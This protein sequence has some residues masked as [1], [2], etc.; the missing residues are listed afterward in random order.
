M[1]TTASGIFRRVAV[2]L[3]STAFTLDDPSASEFFH[4]AEGLALDFSQENNPIP[5]MTGTTR[6]RQGEIPGFPSVSV[7]LPLVVRVSGTAGTVPSVDPLLEG[8]FWTADTANT[9]DAVAA[10]PSP[11]TTTYTIGTASNVTA[12]TFVVVKSSNFSPA[13]KPEGR[14]CTTNSSGAL[15]VTPPHSAAPVASSVISATN[16]Y[17]LR[18][19]RSDALSVWRYIHDTANTA[20]IS[21]AVPG[22]V[23]SNMVIEWANEGDGYL[24]FNFS[25][26][27]AGSYIYTSKTTL[28]AGIGNTTDTTITIS[29]LGAISVG[30]RIVVDSECMIVT[31]KSALSGSGTVTVT[32]GANSTT[33]ATHSNGAT[34]SPYEPTPSRTSQTPIPA[35]YC[36]VFIGPFATKIPATRITCTIEDNITLIR[37]AAGQEGEATDYAPGMRDITLEIEVWL[38]SETVNTL[39]KAKEGDGVQVFVQWGDTV[40]KLVMLYAPNWVLQGTPIETSGDAPIAVTLRGSCRRNSADEDELVLGFG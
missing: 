7:E 39:W 6:S 24:N 5:D 3:E 15:T 1:A 19:G 36:D 9:A 18:A 2:A 28:G 30:S 34:V 16:T 29:D 23:P 8:S 21:E 11:S 10:S 14:F 13:N 31:S 37:S 26:E 33:A 40:G 32:R 38:T 17:A 25:G 4:S 12:K 20:F 27:A 22:W 35:I